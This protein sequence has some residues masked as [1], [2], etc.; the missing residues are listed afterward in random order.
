MPR[1]KLTSKGQTTI[2]LPVR[3][4]LGLRNGDAIDFVF[5]DD[6][7]VAVRSVKRDVLSLEG[8]LHKPGRRAV[9]IED[10]DEGIRETAVARH[11]RSAASGKGRPS[12]PR[13]ER[14]RR[15]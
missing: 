9:S 11:L 2:P 12:M 6:G 14:K 1:S 5:H 10:M 7:S 3:E 8:M 13:R 4:R 15:A